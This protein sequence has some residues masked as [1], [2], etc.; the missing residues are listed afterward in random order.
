MMKHNFVDFIPEELEEG[1]VYV[2]LE[3]GSVA[4][5][6]CCGCGNDV[7]TPLSPTD[8]Q[9]T[10][11]GESVSLYPSIGNWNFVCQSHYWITGNKVKWSG[12]WTK[13]EIETGRKRDKIRKAGYFKERNTLAGNEVEAQEVTPAYRP[14]AQPKLLGW[15][16]NLFSK[17]TKQ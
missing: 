9:L 12:R 4:H 16:I 10:Y 6:C 11:D 7:F 1:V 2:A 15:L 14:K 8:W 5:K 3:L 17:M 13:K